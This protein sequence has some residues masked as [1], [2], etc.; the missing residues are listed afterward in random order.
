MKKIRQGRIEIAL[1]PGPDPCASDA[2]LVLHALG[3]TGA[4]ATAATEFW[5]GPLSSIDFCGHG[6][7]GRLKG[8]GYTPELLAADADAALQ[9]ISAPYL[10]GHGLGAWIA[11]LLAGA[12]PDRVKGALLL[13]G[14]GLSGGGAEPVLEHARRAQAEGEARA[15]QVLREADPALLF[16]MIDLRPV[17][18]AKSFAEHSSRLVLLED[19][20]PR[21]PWWDAIR[22]TPAA[23]V[24]RGPMP[25]AAGALLA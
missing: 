2:A 21:P 10:I 24:V 16:C 20:S 8:G 4:A 1:Y 11:L 22:D 17:A 19:G 6:A 3:S 9:E 23:T 7:S 5:P 15:G 25:E 14:E 13:P 12:R 18:Y